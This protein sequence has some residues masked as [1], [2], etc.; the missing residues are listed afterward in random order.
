VNYGL[1]DVENSDIE[2]SE[3]LGK[4]TGEPRSVVARN[5]DEDDLV[6]VLSSDYQLHAF[7][8]TARNPP[9]KCGL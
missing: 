7:P 9:R 4:G 5:I 3:D 1:P 2:S 8:H 6:H